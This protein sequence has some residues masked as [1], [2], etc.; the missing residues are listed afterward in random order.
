MERP[1]GPAQGAEILRE[2]RALEVLEQAGTDQ[3]RQVLEALA[4]GAP[5]AHLTQGAKAALERL[6]KQVSADQ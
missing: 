5:E 6:A 4:K 2:L 3:A 1:E